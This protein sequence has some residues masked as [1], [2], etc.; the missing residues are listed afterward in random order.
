[1]TQFYGHL[2]PDKQTGCPYIWPSCLDRWGPWGDCT[3]HTYRLTVVMK[4]WMIFPCLILKV[5]LISKYFITMLEVLG[6]NKLFDNVCSMDFQNIYLT[7]TWLNEMCL[8]QKLFPDSFTIF[9]SRVS[10]TKS[11][12]GGGLTVVLSRAC[13]FKCRYDLQLYHECIWVKISTQSSRSSL[14]RNDYPPPPIT[15]RTL[16]LNILVLWRKILILKIKAFDVPLGS[17]EV[18]SNWQLSWPTFSNF[19]H[20]STFFADVGVVKPK[21]CHSLV[22]K[23]PLDLYNSTLH[24]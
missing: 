3:Q 21:S 7:E 6:P 24:S 14:I 19:F 5:N 2:K 20:V 1:M 23:I 12:D 16:Y 11:R 13:T 10:S 22:I 15:N 9:C 18:R 4:T 17:Y 8:D